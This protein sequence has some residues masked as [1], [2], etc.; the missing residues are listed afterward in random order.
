MKFTKKL[1]GRTFLSVMLVAA[2]TACGSKDE[3]VQQPEN[4]PA[5]AA[6]A[7]T[8][9]AASTTPAAT[10]AASET[11]AAPTGDYKEMNQAEL[12]ALYPE[13][14]LKGTVTLGTSTI[15][16]SDL[17]SGWTN[18][19][20]NSGCKYLMFWDYSLV[21][22]DPSE[23]FY[24]NRIVLDSAESVD[25]ADGTRTFTFKLNENLVFNDGSPIDAR[26]YLFT[27]M[28]MSSPEFAGI[29]GSPTY[30]IKFVGYDEFNAGDTKTFSGFRLLD[31]Y[32]FQ[33]TIKSDE[34]PF[35]YDKA[36]FYDSY[37]TPMHVIAPDV[38]MTDDGNGATFSD[39]F[40]TELLRE[41]MLDP[42]N[43][44]RYNPKVTP[45]SYQLESF[46]DTSFTAVLTK[47]PNFLALSDGTK[48]SVEKIVVKTTTQS[49][50]MNELETGQIDMLVGLN[51]GTTIDQGLEMVDTGK[52]GYAA[53][54]RNGYGM[55]SLHCDFGP[56]Q[57]EAVRQAMCYLLDRDEFGRQYSGGY[58]I[59]VDARYSV[60]QW[61]YQELKDE[62]ED[63]L[64]KYTLNIDKA[65][66]LLDGDGWTKNATGGDY[67]PGPGNIRHKE[68]DGELM[69]LVIEWCSSADNAVTDLLAV[70]MPPSADQVGM[71]I[72]QTVQ[73][74]VLDSFYRKNVD[75]P[76]FHMFNMG[77]GFSSPDSPWNSYSTKPQFWGSPYNQ[78]FIK[79]EIL[80][81]STQ[82][83]K[84]T[85]PGDRDTFLKNWKEYV[86]EWNKTLPDIP[87]YA[88]IYH[89]F[90]N[91]R[92]DNYNA[93]P[94]WGWSR[95]IPRCVVTN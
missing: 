53:Y 82:A 42:Q 23:E 54:P 66:E 21:V 25:N 39:N 61:M 47:N 48:P 57:F 6:T 41:T 86:I 35:F 81:S 12:L 89:D 65:N 19:S 36:F 92:L 10:P 87:L 70:M 50:Q 9:P 71:K 33:I 93:T 63:E 7:S 85:E 1:L 84:L 74:S 37:P 90:Y 68:V 79:N 76:F 60:N 18:I 16:N 40:T 78:N 28:F 27:L 15:M 2:L 5:P 69:P 64:T 59:V 31:N 55:I 13:P 95:N 14:V 45:G 62:L 30:G 72:N 43:G 67:V 56:T 4:S 46:D 11:P 91:A 20:P 29:D 44:Y 49:T 80:E 24:F 58:A 77:T 32:T 73:D 52:F 17:Y 51:Q 94:T 22:T 88:N 83:M 38:T 26:N 34:L 3:G 8:A 75:V